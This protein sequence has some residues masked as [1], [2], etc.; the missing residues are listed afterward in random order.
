MKAAVGLL[1]VIYVVVA[2]TKWENV[3][4]VMFV[5]AID[6]SLKH[7]LS[8]FLPSLGITVEGLFIIF[9]YVLFRIANYIHT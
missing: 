5:R 9:Q 4:N 1:P 2:T 6:Y 7:L 3:T 8:S